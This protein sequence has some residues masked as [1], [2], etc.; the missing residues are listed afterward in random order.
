MSATYAIA[1]PRRIPLALTLALMAVMV[2]P[3]WATY[4]PTNFLHFC[5]VATFF[6]LVAAWA[7]SPLLRPCLAVGP[8]V[9]PFVRRVDF[10]SSCL[11]CRGWK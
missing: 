11:A 10:L 7:G 4:D 8:I 3:Y 1:S 2:R 9:P 6:T 5:N